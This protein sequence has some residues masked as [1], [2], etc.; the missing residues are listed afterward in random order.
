[1]SPSLA[2]AISYSGFQLI[3]FNPIG[4]EMRAFAQREDYSRFQLIRFNP[5][6]RVSRMCGHRHMGDV[7]N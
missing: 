6:G 2:L 3:R 5:I 1:M 7:S 4:R